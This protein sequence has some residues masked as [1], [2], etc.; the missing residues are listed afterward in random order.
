MP[1]TYSGSALLS[2][3]AVLRV[4]AGSVPLSEQ[5]QHILCTHYACLISA[6]RVTRGDL[7]YARYYYNSVKQCMLTRHWSPI[8]AA[9]TSCVQ[10]AR[11]A[12]N[13][14]TSKPIPKRIIA[15]FEAAEAAKDDEIEKV[16]KQLLLHLMLSSIVVT[17]D[18]VMHVTSITTMVH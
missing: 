10:I 2:T 11:T 5:Q 7:C 18:A 16:F 8:A 12:E 13:S 1:L 3:S 9:A 14:R 17:V 6:H 15:Q 4:N